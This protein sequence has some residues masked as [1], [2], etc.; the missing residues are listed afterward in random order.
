MV[1]LIQRRLAAAGMHVER[2]ATAREG[3]ARAVAVRPDVVLLATSLPDGDGFSLLSKLRTTPA[4]EGVSI[5]LMTAMRRDADSLRR[6]LELGADDYL[7]KPI[8]EVELVARVRALLRLRRNFLDLHRKSARLAEL[9]EELERLATHD[10]LTGVHN[11]RWLEARLRDEVERT[12][13]YGHPLA[14]VLADVDHFKRVN[15]AHGHPAGDA[16]LR[17]VADTMARAIRRVDS[18][19]RFGGEEFVV[20]APETDG[21]GACILAERLRAIVAGTEAIVAG[22]SGEVALSVTASFG[23]ASLAGEDARAAAD[24]LAESLF[25]AADAALYRAKAGGRN[26]VER[27]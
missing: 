24:D 22:A 2:A 23:V 11:R 10:A 21:D 4:L 25:A 13:R 16:V 5:A 19:A 18:L 20:V 1:E 3:L 15:D 26:R 14:L 8:E 12:K 6:G 9:N 17:C 27:A 7:R